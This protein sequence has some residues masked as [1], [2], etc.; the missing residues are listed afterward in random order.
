M[1]SEWCVHLSHLGWCGRRPRKWA[2]RGKFRFRLLTADTCIVIDGLPFRGLFASEFRRKTWGRSPGDND[3][4]VRLRRPS[5][6]RVKITERGR[7]R[8]LAALETEYFHDLFPIVEALAALQYDDGTP[9]Q[10]GYLGVWVQGSSWVVRL[11][12]KDAEAQLTCE[13]KSLDEAL[14]LLSLLLGAEDAPWEPT[15]KKRRK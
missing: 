4:L 9:R 10:P 8:H 3:L 14:N 6:K 11:T 5:V 12:D 13:G 1:A 2:P 15:A 7:T